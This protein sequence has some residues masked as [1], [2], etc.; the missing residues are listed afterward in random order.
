MYLKLIYF[1]KIILLQIAFLLLQKVESIFFSAYNLLRCTI[2]FV[3]NYLFGKLEHKRKNL[4]L[5]YYVKIFT[6]FVD[7]SFWCAFI[8]DRNVTILVFL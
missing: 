8:T 6:S 3:V 1:S 5:I 2:C 4:G 7:M